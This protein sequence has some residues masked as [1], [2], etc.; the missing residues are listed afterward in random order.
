MRRVSAWVSLIVLSCAGWPSQAEVLPRFPPGSTWNQDVSAQALKRSDSD[1]IIAH[2]STLGGWGS[3]TFNI[4]LSSYYVLHADPG[5]SGTAVVAPFGGDY[6]TPDCGA[7]AMPLIAPEPKPIPLPPGGGIGGTDPP[8][9]VCDTGDCYLLV[10]QGQTL[11]ESWL[12]TV[13]NE[14]VQA[15]CAVSW[16]LSKVYPRAQRGEQC[17]NVDGSGTPIAPLLFNADE[18]HAALQVTDGDLG[19]ALRFL[20]PNSRMK[21]DVYV[22][23]ASS[24][25]APSDTNTNALP[26]GSRLRLKATFAIDTFVAGNHATGG[27]AADAAARVVLRTLRKYG[28]V[29]ADGGNIPMSG[30]SDYYTTH[31]WADLGFSFDTL[32]SLLISDFEVVDTGPEI[33][34]TRACRLTADDFVFIDGFDY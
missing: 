15:S 30:E 13:T 12:T 16:D 31:K 5:I 19:H 22:H 8:G 14:G 28:M 9:Y 3:G 2:V 7:F 29:L 21:K 25:G 24:A 18:M 23:P 26:Y 11:F 32:K 34:V 20:L 4:D 17:L 10:V 6:S 27:D 33:A 1:A